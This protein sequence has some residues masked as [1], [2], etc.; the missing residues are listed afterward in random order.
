MK[1][2]ELCFVSKQLI[3]CRVRSQLLSICADILSFFLQIILLEEKYGRN[4]KLLL[5]KIKN[6]LWILN[7][8]LLS[9]SIFFSLNMWS[10]LIYRWTYFTIYIILSYNY[11]QYR[12][13]MAL[14]TLLLY[15]TLSAL[16]LSLGHSILTTPVPVY[17]SLCIKKHLYKEL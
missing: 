2:L 16:T 9:S 8:T 10:L 13:S 1:T 7:S 5:F 4:V 12:F 17:D 11:I 15:L 14:S 3:G 6:F